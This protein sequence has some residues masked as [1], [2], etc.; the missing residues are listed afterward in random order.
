MP[1]QLADSTILRN[2]EKMI[3]SNKFLNDSKYYK[4][5]NWSMASWDSWAAQGQAGG[6]STCNNDFYNG[7]LTNKRASHDSCRHVSETF[8]LYCIQKIEKELNVKFKTR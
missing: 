1:R 8:C 6:C 4:N 7:T 5:N 2:I 3:E